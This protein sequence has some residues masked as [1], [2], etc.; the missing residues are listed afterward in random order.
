MQWIG[1]VGLDWMTSG[2]GGLNWM[3]A[4]FGGPD[5]MVVELGGRKWGGR[6]KDLGISKV[7]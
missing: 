7:K 4:R 1:W 5:W 6:W 3:A 2:L